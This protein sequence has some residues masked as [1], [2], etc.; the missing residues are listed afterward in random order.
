MDDTKYYFGFRQ[1]IPRPP[2]KWVLCGPF[3]SLDQ[4]KTERKKAKAPDCQV[5]TPFIASTEDEAEIKMHI[6]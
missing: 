2:R 3:D 6:F 1:I 4:A 5:T